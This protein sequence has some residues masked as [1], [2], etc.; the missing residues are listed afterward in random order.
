MVDCKSSKISFHLEIKYFIHQNNL[1]T[2]N[3]DVMIKRNESPVHGTWIHGC[4]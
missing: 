3:H 2:A 4:G 1:P